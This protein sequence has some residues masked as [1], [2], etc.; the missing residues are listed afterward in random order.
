MR[1]KRPGR[2]LATLL[3]AAVGCGDDDA[4]TSPERGRLF[5]VRVGADEF[6]MRAT[7][8]ET[9][10]LAMENLAGGNSLHPQGPIAAGDGGFNSPWN[11]H[12]VPETV[13][14]VDSS[15]ELCDGTPTYVEAHRGDYLAS[16]YCPW[17]ARVIALE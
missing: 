2:V 7:D 17:S 14:M 8:P 11:W 16:G 6:R 12:L 1:S 10:R 3:L 9:I 15:I 4:P 5:R 13:R